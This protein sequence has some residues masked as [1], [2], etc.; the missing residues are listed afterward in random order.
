ML[1]DLEEPI[2]SS[3]SSIIA[4]EPRARRCRDRERELTPVCSRPLI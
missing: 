4:D 2:Q 1:E 3:A